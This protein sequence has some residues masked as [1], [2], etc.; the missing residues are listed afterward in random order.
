MHSRERGFTLIELLVV[1]AIIA[2]L[3]A[4][5]F[6]AF[7]AAKKRAQ[8]SHCL[9]NLKQLS[10]ALRTY[11]DDHQGFMPN[12]WPP[13]T[14]F[15]PNWCGCAAAGG[16]VYLEKGTIWQYVRNS[17]VYRCPSDIGRAALQILKA[18]WPSGMT[19]MDYPLSYSMN[20]NLGIKNADTIANSTKVM[21][22][23]HENRGESITD[24]AINDG[25]Y[26]PGGQDVPGIVHY[27]GST[28]SY[29]DGH[30]VWKPR[31]KLFMEVSDWKAT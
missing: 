13:L 16:W 19:N 15:I 26:V 21:L 3:A 17:K 8:M 24:F 22:L 1:I 23:L 18:N 30:A 31:T 7:L 4:I 29:L 20:H 25:T 12:D 11:A 10:Q 14:P 9:S 2:I 27:D 28:L 5:L 6:P